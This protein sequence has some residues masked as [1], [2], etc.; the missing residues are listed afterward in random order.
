MQF[1]LGACLRGLVASLLLLPGLAYA[2]D[3]AQDGCLGCTDGDLPVCLRAFSEEICNSLGNPKNCDRQRVY[4]D[5]ERHVLIS[6]GRHMS[7]ILSMSRSARKYQ[8]R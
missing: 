4:D 6:T 2:C 7:R 3:P 8:Y 5:A 1:S